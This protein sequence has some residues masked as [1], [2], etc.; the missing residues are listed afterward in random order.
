MCLADQEWLRHPTVPRFAAFGRP[1]LAGDDPCSWIESEVCRTMIRVA[2]SMLIGDRAKYVGLVLGV[3]FT[4]FLVTFAIS[5]L[6]G[7]L[8]FGFALVSENPQADVWVMDPAVASIEPAVNLPRWSL[9]CVRNVEG[10]ASATPLSIATAEARLPNGA[11]TPVEMIAVDDATLA[12]VPAAA[13]GVAARAL[14]ADG[15]VFADEGGT[16]NKLRMPVRRTD[17]WPPDGPH[18]HVPM[19]PIAVGDELVVNDYTLRVAGV[20]HTRPR[21]PPRP[22]LFTTYGNALRVLPTERERTTFIMVSAAGDVAPRELA[23]RIAART[24]LRARVTA[25]F[26]ADSVRWTL[27]NSEDVGDMSAMLAIAACVGLGGTGV[28]LFMFTADNRR[29]YAALEAMGATRRVLVGMVLAQASLCGLLGAGLGLGL[30]AIAVRLAAASGYPFRMMWFNP[31]VGVGAVLVVCLV[32]AGVS[33]R[34]MLKL[35]PAEAFALG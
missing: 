2:I 18:L 14:R 31:V 27:R 8:T 21:F 9:A 23:A 10:V 22:L 26:R 24:G 19:R 1:G 17:W 16:E 12:G 20:T 32:A 13:D 6:C 11:F 25:D 15:A 3:T 4:A 35:Q 28:L 5:Y 29:W 33:I 34:S 7:I 30:C